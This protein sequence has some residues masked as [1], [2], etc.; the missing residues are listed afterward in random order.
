MEDNQPV[1]YEPLDRFG[2]FLMEN[3]RDKG[4]DHCDMLLANRYKA[5][6]LLRL[7]KALASLDEEQQNVVRRCVVSCLDGATH[8]FLFKLHE[9]SDFENDIQILVD[10]INVEELTEAGLHYEPFCEDGW[11]ALYSKYGEAPREG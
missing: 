2:Q 7:Q 10:G 4:S 8:D 5:P 3:L 11:Q 6:A 1:D 9:R